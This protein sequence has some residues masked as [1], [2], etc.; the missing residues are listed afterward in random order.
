MILCPNEVGA[1]VLMKC[2]S[3]WTHSLQSTNNSRVWDGGGGAGQ[4]KKTEQPK[5]V[6]MPQS[7]IKSYSSDS[8]IKLSYG[9]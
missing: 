9:I 6:E 3:F 2:E 5:A 7:L 8:K 4:N 1:G